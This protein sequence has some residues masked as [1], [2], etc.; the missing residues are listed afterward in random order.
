MK[1][2]QTPALVLGLLYLVLIGYIAASSSALPEVVATHFDAS[3]Q[4]DGWMSRAE[5]LRFMTVFGLA[6]PLVVP[7]I[8]YVIRFLP[9]RGLN[10]PNRDYWPAPGRRAETMA[11]LCRHSLWFASMA[12]GFVIGIHYSV[13]QANRLA[14]PQLP[15]PQV[16]TLA[17]CFMAGAAVWVVS[18]IRYFKRVP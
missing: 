13:I 12:L 5:H 1:G 11:Y 6:F 16:L 7:G 10:L 8:V 3:G 17:G 2:L 9:D 15:T 14:Q 4:P 18:L